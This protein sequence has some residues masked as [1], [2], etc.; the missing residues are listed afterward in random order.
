MGVVKGE[1]SIS[2]TNFDKLEIVLGSTLGNGRIG[3]LQQVRRLVAGY[4]RLRAGVLGMRNALLGHPTKCIRHFHIR[5]VDFGSP[6]SATP[7]EEAVCVV[8]LALVAAVVVSVMTL[9]PLQGGFG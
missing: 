3:V 1:A 2:T 9:N 7:N 4:L 8:A 6:K 5:Q